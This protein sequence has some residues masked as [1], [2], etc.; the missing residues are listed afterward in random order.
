M[1]RL[2]SALLLVLLL[3]GWEVY[4]RVAGVSALVVPLPSAVLRTLWD[5]LAGGYLLP[6]LWVTTAEMAMGLA[7]GCTVGFLAGLLLAEVPV[8]RRLFYPYILASQVVPKLALGPLFIVWFGFGMTSTVVITALI[9]FFPLLENTMT[10]LQQV[11][12]NKRE[13]FRMLRAT[14]LQTLLR[15]KIPSGLPVIL[16]GLRVAVVLALVGA[17]VGEFIGGRQGLGASIIAAQ[18]MM[19]STMMFALFIVITVLGMIVYQ[20]AAGLERWLLRR[21]WKG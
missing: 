8:L 21:P 13:L 19:D 11:D 3:A 2:A 20:A 1:V 15:L 16:A 12:P 10:G 14:R 18:G 17:V 7:A 4:C 6:H 5:G 9:C